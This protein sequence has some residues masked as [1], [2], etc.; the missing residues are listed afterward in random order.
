MNQVSFLIRRVFHRT[1]QLEVM[2]V[3]CYGLTPARFHLMRAIEC[4]RQKWVP[5]RDVRELLGVR[6]PTVGRMVSA[7]VRH[8]YLERRRD[9][10]D[11]RRRQVALTRL[12]RRA[13]RCAFQHVVKSGYMREVL[14]RAVSD[15][16]DYSPAPGDALLCVAQA[17]A[18]LVTLQRNLGDNSR[19]EHDDQGGMPPPIEHPIF[20]PDHDEHGNWPG[21]D[22]PLYWWIAENLPLPGVAV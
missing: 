9:P 5:S 16:D 11:G 19:F 2:M 21:D 22:P 13:L 15:G 12:G 20:L 17:M 1:E 10:E 4:Q 8:G 3:R 7:L 14:E 6:G 18:I